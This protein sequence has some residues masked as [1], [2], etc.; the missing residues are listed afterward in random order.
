MPVSRRPPIPRMKVKKTL[1]YLVFIDKNTAVNAI[2]FV[3]NATLMQPTSRLEISPSR[4]PEITDSLNKTASTTETP[5]SFDNVVDVVDE[6]GIGNWVF[7]ES[8]VIQ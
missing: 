2:S 3:P 6:L 5:G 1:S 8:E 4:S 7:T